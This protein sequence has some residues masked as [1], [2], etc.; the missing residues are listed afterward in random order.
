MKNFIKIT[1]SL[2]DDDR[3]DF[4]EINKL[5]LLSHSYQNF[6][7]KLLTRVFSEDELIGKNVYGRNYTGDKTTSKQPLDLKRINFIKETVLLLTR[8]NNREGAWASC[9]IA[10]NRKMVDINNK[11]LKNNNNNVLTSNA[12]CKLTTD[13][14]NNNNNKTENQN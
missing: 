12:A 9:V 4:N 5:R 8:T 7:V 2:S 6:A 14:N 3:Y 11:Y 1:N 10:M 13:T